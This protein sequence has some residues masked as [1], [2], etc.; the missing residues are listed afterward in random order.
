MLWIHATS[1]MI[2]CV[3]HWKD[4]ILVE[5][6]LCEPHYLSG[7]LKEDQEKLMETT[8]KFVETNALVTKCC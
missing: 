8:R 2:L 4:K 3:S 6:I 1:K 5:D 7:S